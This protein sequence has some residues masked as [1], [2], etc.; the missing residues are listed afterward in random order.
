MYLGGSYK[1]KA[2]H[3]QNANLSLE[4]GTEKIF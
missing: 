1:P 2:M 3:L 4:D